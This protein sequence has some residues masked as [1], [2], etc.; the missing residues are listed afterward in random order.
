MQHADNNYRQI[1]PDRLLDA[2]PD[3]LR[4]SATAEAL[5]TIAD[6]DLSE[7]EALEPGR[8]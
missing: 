4:G 3:S 7:L 6:F 5:R 1:N 2:L 8:D